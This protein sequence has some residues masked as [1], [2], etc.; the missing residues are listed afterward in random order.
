MTGKNPLLP[1]LRVRHDGWTH[2]RTQRFLGTLGHTGCI[3]D[4]CRVA[5]I[6][7]T[8]AYRHRRSNPE[9]AAAWKAA[10]ERADQGLTA[11][12]YTRAVEGRETIIIRNGEEYERRITP[13]DSILGLLLKRGDLSGKN[14]HADLAGVPREEIITWTEWSEQHVR[15]N[16][17]GGKYEAPDPAETDRLLNE[18]AEKLLR[19]L[20]AT[21]ARGEKCPYCS[22]PAPPGFPQNSLMA[23]SLLGAFPVKALFEGVPMEQD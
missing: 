23:M 4:A 7:D 10:L 15:F 13:S 20:R 9:F 6:S 2:E 5:G 1:D 17:W 22:Q 8:S 19:G 3:R 14:S 12:A 21:A 11:I 16:Q 18:R